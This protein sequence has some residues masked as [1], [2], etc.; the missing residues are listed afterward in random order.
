M[1][2]LVCFFFFFFFFFFFHA[3]FKRSSVLHSICIDCKRQ[4]Q[5]SSLT[6]V[7]VISMSCFCHKNC[8]HLVAFGEGQSDDPCEARE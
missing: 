3:F 4:D 6:F 8:E 1:L 2:S 5:E 7:V